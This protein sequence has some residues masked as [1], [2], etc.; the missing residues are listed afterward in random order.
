MTRTTRSLCIVHVLANGLLLW[1]A[2]E[3]LSLGE[4]TVARL[5]G[6]AAAA[7]ALLGL[8]CWLHGAAFA[9]FRRGVEPGLGKAL[10]TTLRHLAP[11]LLM[12]MGALALYAFLTW[13]AGYSTTPA[14]KLASWLTLQFRKPIRPATVM[15]YFNAVLW[16]VRWVLL[17]ADLLPLFSGIAARGWR[18]F[19][20]FGW[21]RE[22]RLYRLE[23]PVLVLCALWLPLR[24]LNWV[25]RVNGF[26]MEMLSFTLRAGGAYLLFVGAALLLAWLTS[27]GKPAESQLKTVGSE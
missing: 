6:S 14:A 25:P 10:R 19:G 17:P 15:R 1:L 12:T 13:W 3:W 4:S 2:Y 27:R 7:L 20:E 9:S 8:A 16:M 26:R 18:G 22:S 5:A 24:L 11:L 21:R 23:A